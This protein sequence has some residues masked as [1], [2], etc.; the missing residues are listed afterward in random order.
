MVVFDSRLRSKI[1]KLRGNVAYYFEVRQKFMF[2]QD[3][4]K[5]PTAKKMVDSLEIFCS[6]LGL[7]SKPV[8]AKI[9]DLVLSLHRCREAEFDKLMG[10]DLSQ[11]KVIDDWHAAIRVIQSMIKWD[12]RYSESDD[13]KELL[14]ELKS[15]VRKYPEGLVLKNFQ[16]ESLYGPTIYEIVELV[17]SRGNPER[18][19]TIY[20][21]LDRLLDT[22]FPGTFLRKSRSI[23]A[24]KTAYQDGKRKAVNQNKG[25]TP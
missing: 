2:K 11:G 5:V 20:A 24:L 7:K 21:E 8:H 10:I 23:S 17:K 9:S 18:V 16:A 25:R 3:R 15:N 6:K 12:Y 19:K 4:F 14:S 22:I 1:S 13:L